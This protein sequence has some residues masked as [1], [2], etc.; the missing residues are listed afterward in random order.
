LSYGRGVKEKT[1]DK[2]LSKEEERRKG[3][4]GNQRQKGKGEKERKTEVK[5][6]A[7]R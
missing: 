2:K 3:Y 5:T 6:K 1:E 7:I 4:Q